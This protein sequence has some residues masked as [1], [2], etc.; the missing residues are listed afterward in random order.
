MENI[1]DLEQYKRD[2]F[3]KTAHPNSVKIMEWVES[4][5]LGLPVGTTYSEMIESPIWRGG[6]CE[7]KLDI[8]LM[9][10]IRSR[11]GPD[12]WTKK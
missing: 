4:F 6:N 2:Q 3:E 10:L 11:T 5:A 9:M 1:S 12:K 7:I 8:L